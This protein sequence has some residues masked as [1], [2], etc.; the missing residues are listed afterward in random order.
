MNTIFR[1]VWNVAK[2]A[3]EAVSDPYRADPYGLF[4]AGVCRGRVGLV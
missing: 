3:W 1:V 4:T 2:R